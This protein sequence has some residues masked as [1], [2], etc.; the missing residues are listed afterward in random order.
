MSIVTVLLLLASVLAVCFFARRTAPKK[1]GR[2]ERF[3]KKRL[4]N[5]VARY[6]RFHAHWC[7]GCEQMHMIPMQADGG[8]E[9]D[10]NPVMP[11]Y[12]PSVIADGAIRCHYTITRG[13]IHFASDSE[14]TMAGRTV[15]LPD[16]PVDRFVDQTSSE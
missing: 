13:Q 16:L 1:Q 2:G 8:W 5:K 4:S 9:W 3:M 7:P 12:R 10:G 6:G 11:S 15:I 14:H